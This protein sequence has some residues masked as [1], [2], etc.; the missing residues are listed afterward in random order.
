M[1][2]TTAV[3]SVGILRKSHPSP[4]YHRVH[5]AVCSRCLH[6]SLHNVFAYPLSLPHAHTHARRYYDNTIF[7]RIVKDFLIQGGDPTGTGMGGD[8]VYG[9]PF[10]N[11]IHSRL[12]FQRRGLVAM[13][14]DEEGNGSQFFITLNRA[15]DLYVR[16]CSLPWMNRLWRV[17]AVALHRL[18]SRC[19]LRLC[20]RADLGLFPSC[21]FSTRA[22]LCFLLLLLF[23]FFRY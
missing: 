8:S 15:D 7:H 22:P 16:H 6:P 17:H 13:V 5:A 1:H 14:N 2:D 19:H 23:V 11:E 12:K 10:K 18:F 21:A 9:K 3:E 4:A 20:F